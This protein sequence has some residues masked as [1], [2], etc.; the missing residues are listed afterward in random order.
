MR[1]FRSR[2][3]DSL[4]LTEVLYEKADRIARVTINRPQRYNAYS[5]GALEELATALRD[6]AHDDAVG[7]IVLT[8]A[9]D[10]AFCTGGDVKEYAEEYVQRPRDYWKY[11]NLFRDYIEAIVDSGKPTIARLNGMAVGGGNE[12]QLACDLSVMAEHA[13]LRQ[14]GT[15]VGS[16]ACGGATQWLPLNV[17][18]KRAREMVMLNRPVPARQA[19][20]WGLVNRVAPSVTKDGQFV[21]NATPEQIKA[22]LDGRDGYGL[23]LER[24]DQEVDGL[25]K[26]LLESFPECTRYTKEQTNFLKNFVWHSTVGHA[27]E[28]LA[29]H[30]AC[31]EPIEGM[32]AF[33][34][35]RRVD[36]AGMRL[37]GAED[38]SPELPWG[39]YAKRCP[40]CNAGG[41]PSEFEFCGRCGAGLGAAVPAEA[42]A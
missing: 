33:V 28:W 32:N 9:G 19:L 2:P 30:Y 3:A 7:V 40:K 21:V 41:L 25:A 1:H 18:D 14:V 37:K 11:M 8:G 29:L 20:E 4:G 39:G 5:T 42:K 6:A 36:F 12:S 35:K 16:V 10:R 27:R 17:G 31:A 24:L 15:H 22:A 13:V 38:R 34:E 23:S 26:A